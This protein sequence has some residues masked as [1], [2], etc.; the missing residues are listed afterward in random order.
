VGLN[1]TLVLELREGNGDKRKRETKSESA[2]QESKRKL[3]GRRGA[4]ER[5][6]AQFIIEPYL[7]Y[8]S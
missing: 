7:R 3:T 1:T 4:R 8:R 2:S 6:K 5:K